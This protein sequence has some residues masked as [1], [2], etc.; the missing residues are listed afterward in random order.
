MRKLLALIAAAVGAAVV[1]KSVK[2][3]QAESR[4]WAE[5][6]DRPAN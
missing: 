4:L 1:A 2:D 3:N 5:A 6:T